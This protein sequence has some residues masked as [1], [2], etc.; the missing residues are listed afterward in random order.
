MPQASNSCRSEHRLLR[1]LHVGAACQCM[2]RGEFSFPR[3]RSV[4]TFLADG[5]VVVGERAVTNRGSDRIARLSP[6]DIPALQASIPNTLSSMPSDL[7]DAGLG[8]PSDRRASRQSKP[9]LS[10]S[11]ICMCVCLRTYR[12]TH[13]LCEVMCVMYRKIYYGNSMETCI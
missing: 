6:P 7:S 2:L 13:V 4:V 1:L 5:K 11:M 8:R 9:S 10:P 3:S 12:S